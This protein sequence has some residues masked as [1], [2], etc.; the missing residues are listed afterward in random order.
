MN[1]S[2]ITAAIVPIFVAVV[3]V[4]G[5]VKKVDVYEAFISGA[6]R[7]AG[8]C[9]RVLPYMVGM[10][11][12]V[13]MLE[14]SGAFGFLGEWIAPLTAAIGIP[15]EVITLAVMRP[16]S[17]GASLGLLAGLFTSF[18]A[19]SYG[20]RVA[21]VF[22][23][24]SETLFYTVSLYFGTAGVK[25]TRYVIPVALATDFLGLILSCIICT[26]YFGG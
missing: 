14:A 24:S 21:S 9:F 8:L 18:G 26:L 20:G 5:L 3:V 4:Y 12:A 10:I 6:K 25:K 11:F 17:G 16:F 7:G 1:I 2:T 13:R 15:A 19:D 23:G 22:M